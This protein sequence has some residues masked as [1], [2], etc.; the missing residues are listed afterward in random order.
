VKV[1][2]YEQYTHDNPHVVNEVVDPDLC[3]RCGACEPACP[4]DIIRFNEQRYPYITNESEC[5]VN[6]VRCLKVCPGASIDLNKLDDEI[7]GKRPHPQS[8]AGVVKGSYV[9]YAKR[10]DIRGRAASGG[11]TTGLLAYMLEHKLIDGALVLGASAEG[12]PWSQK[13]FIARSVEDL[14]KSVKSKYL[15]VPMLRPL[16]EMEEVEGNY[17]VVA[18][19]CYVQA[20]RLYMKVSP[21]LRKRV[22]LI[23]GLYCN[24]VFEPQLFN[25]LCKSRDV[26]P[27]EVANLDFRAGKWPGL[28]EFELKDGRKLPAVGQEEYKD[29]FNTLKLGYTPRRCDMCVDFSAEYADIAVG[30]P[31]LRGADGEYLYPDGYT[32]VLVRTE[33]GMALTQAAVQAGYLSIE[34]V[35]I[36]TWMANFSNSVKHKRADIPQYIEQQRRLGRKVPEYGR[37]I[38]ASLEKRSLWQLRKGWMVDFRHRF[39]QNRIVRPLIL[40]VFELW[41]MLVYFRWNRRRKARSFVV[42]HA[43]ILERARAILKQEAG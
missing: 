5:R 4:F 7:H 42:N 27:S 16:Q 17:A 31:W 3:V 19:P 8:L 35:P 28:L 6:C 14:K 32:A 41:P 39:L 43:R 40:K 15:A 10:E 12:E 29:A 36:E 24:G 38:D 30:D 25:D 18:L 9:S 21:K 33:A 2:T 20:L 22:K 23:I 1:R 37:V 13:P 26:A 11:F 34:A